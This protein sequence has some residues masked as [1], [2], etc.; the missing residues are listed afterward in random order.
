MN[1]P[2]GILSVFA[3]AL[4]AM[5]LSLSCGSDKVPP[6]GFCDKDTDCAQGLICKQN[7]CIE[8]GS[9]DCDPVCGDEFVC[10]DG[11]CVPIS[12]DSDKDGDGWLTTDD[13]DDLDPFTYPADPDNGLP[14]GFEFCDGKD[15]DC[16]G[17]TDEDCRPCRTGDTQPCGTDQGECTP[18]V[19]TCTDGIFGEC[20]GQAPVAEKD[21]GLDNDCDGS[22]D[23]G[24]PCSNGDSQDCGSDVGECVPGQQICE[25]AVWGI[26]QG[27]MS[28]AEICDNKDNDCDGQTDDGFMAGLFCEG[29]GECAAG[30]FECAS[31]TTI[32]CSTEPGGSQDQSSTDICNGLDDNCDGATDEAFDIGESCIGTGLCGNGSRECLNDSTAICSSDPGGSQ[33]QSLTDICDGYDNDCDGSTDEDY[34]TGQ[35]CE[36]EGE[37]GAGLIECATTDTTVCSTDPGG[38]QDG[39]LVETCDGLDN[40]CDTETDEGS[41]A[42]LCSP[43]PP[44]V[45][46][47]VCNAAESSCSMTDP[48]TDCE[49]GWWD[50]NGDYDDGCEVSDDGTG[51]TC[52]QAVMLQDISDAAGGGLVEITGQ[53]I[54]AGDQDWYKITGLDELDG[55]EAIDGCDDYNVEIVFTSKPD[56]IVFDVA[57]DLCTDTICQSDD[58]FNYDYDPDPPIGGI[59]ECPCTMTNQPG[60]NMCSKEDRIFYIRVYRVAGYPVTDEEYTI[61]ISNGI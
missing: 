5:L 43:L 14:G 29:V 48:A 54:P 18:G 33:D 58:I 57:L 32:R 17:V 8:P 30:N 41:D 42:E 56:G 22:T 16:D 27:Q 44:H 53:L 9:G 10:R 15:N 3:T 61:E 36:G 19:Q 60:V 21:D 55:D 35:A 59:G 52:E 38:S 24:L 45:V 7:I 46:N 39:S 23:E 13:C 25:N 20:S 49:T 1:K 51:N 4:V 34:G 50:F 11:E 12:P 2:L 31:E 47:A 37:C 40:D 28:A 26:C 6:G